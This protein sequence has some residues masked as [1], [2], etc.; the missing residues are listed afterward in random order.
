MSNSITDRDT[1][2]MKEMWGTTKLITDYE[3]NDKKVLQEV[4][5]DPAKKSKLN[6]Q[7]IFENCDENDFEYGVEPTYKLNTG[8]KVL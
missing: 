6:H 7:D 5:Y 1:N 3:L 4:M 8:Q 2:Y